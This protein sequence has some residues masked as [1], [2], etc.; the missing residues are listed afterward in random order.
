MVD[1]RNALRNNMLLTASR[2]LEFTTP[3][4]LEGRMTLND[5]WLNGGAGRLTVSC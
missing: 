5:K 1:L 2:R 3:W 4:L